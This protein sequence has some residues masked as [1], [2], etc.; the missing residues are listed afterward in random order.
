MLV[1]IGYARVSRGEQNL[2]LQLD[3][4]QGCDEIF[5]EIASRSSKDR[6]VLDQAIARLREGDSLVVWK[7]DRFGG[8]VGHV[9]KCLEEIR[10]R[11]ANLVSLVEQ[12]DSSTPQGK[13]F[14]QMNAIYA[15]LEVTWIRQRTRAG[16]EAAR[17]RGRTGGRRV[18]INQTTID[19]ARDLRKAGYEVLEIC[20]LLHLSKA[21][22]YRYCF[23]EPAAQTA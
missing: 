1:K 15:E 11:G 22:Y 21:T 14:L 12:L 9:V 19:S 20:T 2:N 3:A 7:L 10:E 13:A 4:L 8:N 5:Q 23:S 6:E 17:A 18:A 16:L